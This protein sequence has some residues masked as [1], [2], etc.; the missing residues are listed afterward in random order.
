MIEA[1]TVTLRQRGFSL[2]ELMV[3]IAIGIFLLAGAITLF[4]NSKRTY[5]EQ[6]DMAR[7]QESL[8]FASQLISRDIRVAGYFGCANGISPERMENHIIAGATLLDLARGPIQ[9]FD[10]LNGLNWWPSGVEAIPNP[11]PKNADGEDIVP[12]PLSDAITL[13][14]AGGP[15]WQ[16]TAAMAATT[17]PIAVNNTA[18]TYCIDINDNPL[19]AC[20]VAAAVN[21]FGGSG[22]TIGTG[23]IVAVG[24][25]S[26]VD[27]FDA[28]AGT[29][30]A[31]VTH[32]QPAGLQS[33]YGTDAVVT[34]GT[35]VRY[36]VGTDPAGT[37]PGLYREEPDAGGGTR[38]T[39]LIPGVENMQIE[40]GVNTVPDVPEDRGIADVYLAAGAA[41]LQTAAEWAEVVSVRIGLLVRS[42]NPSAGLELPDTRTYNLLGNVIDPTDD[43]VK[44]RTLET[45]VLLRN[46]FS[47]QNFGG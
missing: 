5:T 36:F 19:P 7:I 45:T 23:D 30:A 44:R 29:G 34:R 17:D 12:D 32:G 14:H 3:A 43:P 20:N 13:R 27:V 22:Q 28:R 42:L 16:V 41:Q 2:V 46:A 37:P 8:R 25:C 1:T 18:Q 26:T 47:A 40:Y 35:V 6:D 21:T 39:L 38:S 24:N 9:G 15:K 10:R 33:A 31:T 4:L 11:M